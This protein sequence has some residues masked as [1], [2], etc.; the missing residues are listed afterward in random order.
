MKT[1]HSQHSKRG[2][3]PSLREHVRNR[4]QRPHATSPSQTKPMASLAFFHP[5]LKG[6]SQSLSSTPLFP[7]LESMPLAKSASMQKK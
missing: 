7:L 5:P 6:A 4:N 3:S 1:Y 2:D